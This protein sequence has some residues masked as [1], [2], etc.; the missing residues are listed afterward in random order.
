MNLYNKYRP[1]VWEKI[2]GNKS[3]VQGLLNHVHDSE[4][5]HSYLFSG[6]TGTGKTTMARLFG[7][8][9]LCNIVE[10]N[11][12]ENNGVDFAREF[13]T[14]TNYRGFHGDTVYILDECHRLTVDAQNILLKVLEEPPEHVYIILCSTEPQK[15]IKTILNRCVRFDTSIPTDKE[16]FNLLCDICDAEE[17]I[18]SDEVLRKIVY[19]SQGVP[20]EAISILSSIGSL[21]NDELQLNAV[22]GIHES[23]TEVIHLCRALVQSRPWKDVAAILKTIEAVNPETV[24]LYVLGYMNKVLLS[25]NRNS[26]A[27]VALF[28]FENLGVG[29]SKFG[30]TKACFRC[31]K[32]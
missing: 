31:C 3:Q 30:I 26:S 9:I 29:P 22:K 6:P 2:V 16:V 19:T 27:F 17:M 8:S 18:V 15:L 25:G 1:D 12:S 23:E 24:R 21:E 5:P 4:R 7:K 20:R 32:E 28:E 10:I 13:V 14:N 11:V